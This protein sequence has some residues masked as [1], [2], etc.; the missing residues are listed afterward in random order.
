MCILSEENYAKINFSAS[1]V[2]SI[3]TSSEEEM[4]VCVVQLQEDAQGEATFAVKSPEARQEGCCQPCCPW[5][6]QVL[7]SA[8]MLR[9]R[10]ASPMFGSPEHS[11]QFLPFFFFSGETQLEITRQSKI[12][13]THI[14]SKSLFQEERRLRV[15]KTLT[16]EVRHQKNVLHGLNRSIHFS[17]MHRFTLTPVRF[18]Y[19]HTLFT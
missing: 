8:G 19:E 4:K 18:S 5:S 11:A 13:K 16:S 9:Q 12:T 1:G 14:L 10:A 6:C 2:R 7:A 15:K 3:D 17:Y